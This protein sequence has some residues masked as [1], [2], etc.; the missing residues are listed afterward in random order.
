MGIALG[1]AISTT[2]PREVYDL[3]DLYPQAGQGRPSV[4][5]APLKRPFGSENSGA[6]RSSIA[7]AYRGVLPIASSISSAACT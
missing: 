4:L 7:D 6:R 3:M 2:I 1:W 5:Y